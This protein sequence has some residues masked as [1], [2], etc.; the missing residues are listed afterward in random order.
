M[1]IGSVWKA[2]YELYA[3]SAMAGQVG[4]S[5]QQIEALCNGQ[6]SA[7]LSKED[8]A[9]QKFT[10]QIVAKR[11]IDKKVYFNAQQIFG[12]QGLVEMLILIGCSQ[13]VCGF[14]NA[15]SIPAPSANETTHPGEVR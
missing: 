8:I 2:P 5:T 3:H 6:I 1:L 9:A 14:L 12:D 13:I 10:G 11:S 7:G 4:L 15:F